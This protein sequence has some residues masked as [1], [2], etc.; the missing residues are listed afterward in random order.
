MRF[1]LLVAWL[2]VIGGGSAAASGKAETIRKLNKRVANAKGT[3][4]D[5]CAAVF[6][7]FDKYV[8]PGL[9]SGVVRAV[10]TDTSW[11]TIDDPVDEL[12]GKVPVSMDPDDQTFVVH[13]AGTPRADMNNKAWSEWVIYGRIK[14]RTVNGF[15]KFLAG[16]PA[17][18]LVEFAL[19]YPDGHIDEHTPNGR[20]LIKSR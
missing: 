7:L 4:A 3:R 19:M 8:T 6:E 15:K 10:I 9:T 14:G 17:L 1:S 16:S 11:I 2:A 5:R 12:G 18:V 13:C 20:K